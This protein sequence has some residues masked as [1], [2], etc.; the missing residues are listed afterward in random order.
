MNDCFLTFAPKNSVEN[1]CS[2]IFFDFG[3]DLVFCTQVYQLF[4]HSEYEEVCVIKKSS[5]TMSPLG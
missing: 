2:G 3:L 1:A 4:C 5:L